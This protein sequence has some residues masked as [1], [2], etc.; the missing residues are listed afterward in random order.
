LTCGLDPG[1]CEAES[2]LLSA[3]KLKKTS[4]PCQKKEV[5]TLQHLNKL[6]V[7]KE[8]FVHMNMNILAFKC[9]ELFLSGFYIILEN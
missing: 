1:C 6:S 5:K 3:F 8:L 2:L 9:P 7:Q 4:V